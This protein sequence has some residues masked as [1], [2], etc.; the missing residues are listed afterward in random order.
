MTTTPGWLSLIVMAAC[1]GA[2]F[3]GA[4]PA[5]Y[6]ASDRGVRIEVLP[7]RVYVETWREQIGL[8]DRISLHLTVIN[9]SEEAVQL[10][11]VR[12]AFAG[13]EG[14]RQEVELSGAA[15]E[16]RL[17]EGA[18]AVFVVPEIRGHRTLVTESHFPPGAVA[19]LAGN[20]FVVPH[21]LRAD[22]VAIEV[23]ARCTNGPQLD[24]RETV[25]LWRYEPTTAFQLPFDGVWMV[26]NGHGPGPGHPVN[27]F[28]YDFAKVNGVSPHAGDGR[29]LEQWYGY[30]EAILAAA[31]GAVVE[32]NQAPGVANN[33]PLMPL[34]TPEQLGLKPDALTNTLIT[35][36]RDGIHYW[37]GN[38]CWQTLSAEDRGRLNGAYVIIQHGP[39][40]FSFY[41]HLQPGSLLA[42]PGDRVQ[43][44]QPIG[45]CGSA[46]HANGAGLHFQ[47][48]YKPDPACG[49][50]VAFTPS[51][52]PETEPIR[53]QVM[54]MLGN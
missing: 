42:R 28:A 6:A 21:A 50:P 19:V 39:E 38:L 1:L 47:L 36:D 43:A 12:F 8:Y 11:A 29:K 14:G 37:P 45:R 10:D 31:D 18:R 49:L 54:W 34:P 15:L 3:S 41:V 13:P 32:A 46:G 30:G 33:L 9:D 5:A 17:A 52:A 7:E 25:K 26:T 16:S 53:P 44:G 24:L 27:S 20:Q 23:K 22:S 48:L 40:E 51:R 35:I 4:S 2:G